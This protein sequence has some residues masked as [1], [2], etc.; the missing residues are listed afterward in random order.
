MS[1]D[2][3]VMQKP[4]KVEFH[5]PVKPEVLKPS[6][7]ANLQNIH[8]K[9]A[10]IINKVPTITSKVT[11]FNKVV[12]SGVTKSTDNSFTN[13]NV[14]GRVNIRIQPVTSKSTVIKSSSPQATKS[15]YKPLTPIR[16][17]PTIKSSITTTVT[18]TT[19][20]S[21][22]SS[23]TII[24]TP[25][26]VNKTLESSSL[27]SSYSSFNSS[28]SSPGINLS[29]AKC[30]RRINYSDTEVR[31]PVSRRNAR[32][33]NRVKQVSQGFAILRQHVPQAA[34]K[35]KLSKV[36]TLRC[37]VDYIRGLQLLLDDHPP[38]QPPVP[39]PTN[40]TH[41]HHH[42]HHHHHQQLQQQH[43]QMFLQ[44]H[45][46]IE[47]HILKLP[48]ADETFQSPVSLRYDGVAG[49]F[50]R[51]SPTDS[52]DGQSPGHPFF[53]D[54]LS[55]PSSSSTAAHGM[56]VGVIKTE[57]GEGRAY[58]REEQDLLDALAWWQHNIQP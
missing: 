4:I 23:T 54:K 9:T 58:A 3:V 44:P 6:N 22:S 19:S 24:R 52:E 39:D 10:N 46:T 40:A 53:S 28:S 38:T 14:L 12:S 26:S 51:T 2:V 8:N 7:T 5:S 15:P 41:L 49:A 11:N 31:V 48:V 16:P 18:T 36:E 20:R 13:K 47:P 29:P 27:S 55:P 43:P 57:A 1:T 30:R 34:R 37:A 17:S 35:K 25:P 21:P 32:E 33:R 45:H 42:H 56:G 50:L